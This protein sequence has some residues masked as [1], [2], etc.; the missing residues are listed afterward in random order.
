MTSFQLEPVTSDCLPAVARFLADFRGRDA[1]ATE[2]GEP[3]S[4]PYYMK[5]LTW[6]L[7]DNP[8]RLDQVPLG[9]CVRGENG[10]ILGVHL[11]HPTRFLLGDKRLVGL[12]SGDFFI[13][14][15]ARIQ[16]FFMFRQFLHAPHVDFCYALTCNANSS[17]LWQTQRVPA[18]PDCQYE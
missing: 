4:E 6:R 14:P 8:H 9:Q 5:K 11:Q 2:E 10:A 1:R 12:C 3:V 17:K 13:D 16:G 18:V 15:M 7:L